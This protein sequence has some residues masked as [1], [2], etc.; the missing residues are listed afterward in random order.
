MSTEYLTKE[1]IEAVAYEA[2]LYTDV[3]VSTKLNART[4]DEYVEDR[5]CKDVTVDSRLNSIEIDLYEFK[6][7]IRKEIVG[8]LI[9]EIAGK[10][11]NFVSSIDLESMSDEE[12]NEALEK[13]LYE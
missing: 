12:F 11:K 10:F 7:T 8:C 3:S 2:R 5:L 4:F 1:D 13:L 9:S 6:E